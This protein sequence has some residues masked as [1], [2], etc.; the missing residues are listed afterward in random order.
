MFWSNQYDLRLQTAGLFVG[1]EVTIT[2]GNSDS[3]SWSL[4]YLKGERV[5]AIDCVNTGKDFVKRKMLISRGSSG[6]SAAH[7][8]PSIPLKELV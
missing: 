4:V 8:D 6:L 3:R 5:I 1:Y 7:E 2:R